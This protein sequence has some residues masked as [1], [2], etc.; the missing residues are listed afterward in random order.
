M[1]G[2]LATQEPVSLYAATAVIRAV[3]E[4]WKSE[5]P[6]AFADAVGA[7]YG[8]RQSAINAANLSDARRYLPALANRCYQWNQATPANVGFI[9]E[10]LKR[11]L[12]GQPHLG[13]DAA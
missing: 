8:T 13:L 4:H 2:K 9:Q 10:I 11:A 6:E 1:R 7:A 12:A 3:I 5:L